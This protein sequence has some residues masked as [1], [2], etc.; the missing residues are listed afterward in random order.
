MAELTKREEV[1]DD[2]K[3]K[4]IYSFI[5]EELGVKV[6]SRE[7]FKKRN[8]IVHFPF[9]NRNGKPKYGDPL[10]ITFEGLST[11]PAGFLK[12]TKTGL[13][14]TREL[15]PL[16]DRLRKA[17]PAL[18]HV[19]VNPENSASEI[20]ATK[21]VFN[22]KDIK[23]LRS[24]IM[25][26][27]AK[28]KAELE[29]ST[30]NRLAEQFPKKFKQQKAGY[31][32]GQLKEFFT[33]LNVKPN[34]LSDS[35][36]STLVRMVGQIPIEKYGNHS[37][38]IATK[39]SL[40]LL[41]VEQLVKQYKSLLKNKTQTGNLESKWQK[42]FSENL[43][44]FNF[45]YVEKFEKNLIFGDSAINIPDFI[46]LNSLNYLEVFE[47]KTH[48]TPLLGFD[49]GRKNFYW[50][51]DAAKA[52]SQAENYLY[53]L[54]THSETIIHNIAKQYGIF[55]VEIIRPT[56]YIVASTKSTLA[57]INT[58]KSYKGAQLLKLQNDFRRLNNSLKDIKF[59]LYDELLLIFETTMK[60]L[61]KQ[62]E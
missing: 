57:G 62:I 16:F 32:P 43:L 15:L 44:Y 13:G 5:N 61:A 28:Q 46:L 60:N 2:L 26:I 12:T 23:D 25:G 51:A 55:S 1:T 59:I 14:F 10:K 49:K 21:A 20:T 52:I 7:V 35:D 11:I 37:E 4:T 36:I 41:F 30:N 31:S 50:S 34:L 39:A 6:K 18:N 3:T 42:F 22:V 53:S 40:D 8:R 29:I 45:G 33:R 58:N 9:N 56:V 17:F 24:L 47:I 48:L 54:Q 19:V 27:Q 38:V